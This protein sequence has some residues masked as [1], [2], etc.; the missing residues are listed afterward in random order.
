MPTKRDTRPQRI[1]RREV[2]LRRVQ[3]IVKEDGEFA[4]RLCTYTGTLIA[5]GHVIYWKL[6]AGGFRRVVAPAVIT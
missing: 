3:Y 6:M 5:V 2:K 1:L 4:T